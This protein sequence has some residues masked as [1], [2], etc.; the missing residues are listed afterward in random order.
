MPF[1]STRGTEIGEESYVTE[2]DGDSLKSFACSEFENEKLLH[3]MQLSIPCDVDAIESV[4]HRVMQSIRKTNC[5]QES[6]FEV[7]LALREALANAI[8][9]GC[10]S[11]TTKLIQLCVACDEW[12]GLLIV[13]RDPGSGFDPS[14]IPSPVEGQNIYSLHGRGI[15]LM[16]QFMDEVRFESGGREIRM[17]KKCSK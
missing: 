9:H 16:N 2:K 17:R 11:D 10:R 12:H 13:V 3:H 15:F 1:S 7:E 14:A 5:V 4:V 8:V 6:H